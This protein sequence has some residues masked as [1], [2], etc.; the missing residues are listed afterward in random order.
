MNADAARQILMRVWDYL[1]RARIRARGRRWR[2]EVKGRAEAEEGTKTR[3]GQTSRVVDHRRRVWAEFREGQRQAAAS[4]LEA[5][6]VLKQD[7]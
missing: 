7:R 3:N 1:C 6:R 4:C 5:D 2:W